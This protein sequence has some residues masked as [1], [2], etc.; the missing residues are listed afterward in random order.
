MPETE[1]RSTVVELSND[2]D[3]YESL[4][5]INIVPGDFVRW[6]GVDAE[7]LMVIIDGGKVILAV[8][9]PSQDKRVDVICRADERLHVLKPIHSRV[10]MRLVDRPVF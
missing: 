7:I 8:V 5:A 4:R 3:D 2:G 10:A 6:F 1:D 9:D